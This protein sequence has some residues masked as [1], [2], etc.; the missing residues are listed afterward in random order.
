VVHKRR[1]P[2][3]EKILMSGVRHTEPIKAYSNLSLAY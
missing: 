1:H 3:K 2:H